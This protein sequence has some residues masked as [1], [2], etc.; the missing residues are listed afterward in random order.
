MASHLNFIL[1]PFMAPGHITPM[2]NMAHSLSKHGVAAAIILTHFD[3]ARFSSAIDPIRLLKI[4]FPSSE[5][6]LPP[7]CQSADTLPSHDLLPNFAAAI[8]MLQ[9]PVRQMLRELH[10]TPSCIISDKLLTWTA[11]TCDELQLPRIV[12]D[13]MNC[14]TQLVTHN[15]CVSNVYQTDQP[16]LV[17]GLPDRVELTRLQLPGFFNPGPKHVPGFRE[18]VRETEA[19]AYG[20]V[21]NSFE[22]LEKSYFH[23]FRKVRGGKVWCVGPLSLCSSKNMV[24]EVS[25]DSDPCLKWLDGREPASVVYACLG[26]L[27]RPSPAQFAELALGLEASERPFILVAKGAEIWKWIGDEGIEERTRERGVFVRDWAPQEA[28]LSQPGV[29]AFLTHCGWNSTLEGICAGLPMV[30]WPL[31]AEQFLNEKLVVGIL[32]IGVGVGAKCVVHVGEEEGEKKV[33][34]DGIKEAI[35][36]VM[37]KGSEGCKRRKR[38]QEFAEIAKGAVRE[39]GSSFLNVEDLIQDIHRFTKNKKQIDTAG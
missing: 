32:E 5:A 27:S 4:R 24:K 1:I 26:S 3:A 33:R 21:V 8:K 36:M 7:A 11:A 6:G 13:G 31:F 30:T 14:F 37:D 18:Q 39:G 2:I 23:E 17:P 9:R 20:V 29:G 15:L 34:R 38:A 28:I 35:E 22:E 25:I 12:F 16:F 10:P 19:S